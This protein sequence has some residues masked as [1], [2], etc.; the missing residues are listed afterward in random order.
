[1]ERGGK[2]VGLQE[3]QRK[4][5]EMMKTMKCSGRKSGRV[6][7][8]NRVRRTTVMVT[9]IP[10]WKARVKR[11]RESKRKRERKGKEKWKWE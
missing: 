9:Q 8:R 10:V 11:K 6:Q 1:M 2:I 4:T 7:T 5:E 3:M